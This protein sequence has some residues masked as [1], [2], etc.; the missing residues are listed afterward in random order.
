MWR[1]ARAQKIELNSVPSQ[2]SPV[3]CA[4]GDSDASNAGGAEDHLSLV[5]GISRRQR[6]RLASSGVTRA[7]E[8][9]LLSPTLTVNGISAESLK[10]IRDQAALQVQGRHESR[11]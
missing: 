9:G 4:C 6:D 2:S 7:T 10:R 8:L 3:R 11:G 1:R 5:A